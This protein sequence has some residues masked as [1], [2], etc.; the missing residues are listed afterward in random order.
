MQTSPNLLCQ[1]ALEE[2]MAA[3]FSNLPAY[4]AIG[5]NFSFHAAQD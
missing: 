5:L 2:K 3:I 1:F 4:R